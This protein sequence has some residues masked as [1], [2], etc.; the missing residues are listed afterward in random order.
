MVLT[1]HNE[2]RR[3]VARGDQKNK[4]GE[5]DLP[6]AKKMNELT[7]DCNMERVATDEAAKC[8]DYANNQLGVN[9]NTF[10]ASSTCNI[11]EKTQEVLNQWWDE[12]TTNGLGADQKYLDAS[13]L[14]N[15]ANMVY[16]ETN[17]FACSFAKCSSDIR[18]VCIYNKLGKENDKVLYEAAAGADTA[19]DDCA[20]GSECVARLCQPPFTLAA[21][22]PQVCAT[23][24]MTNDMSNMAVYMHNYYRALLGSGWAEDKISTYAPLA[25]AMPAL[26]YDCADLG[27][28][29]A[30]RAAACKETPD[31]PTATRSQNHLA[32]QNVNIDP[33]D[34]L[35]ELGFRFQEVGMSNLSN[36]FSAWEILPEDEAP[37]SIAVRRPE[38]PPRHYE[39]V[40]RCGGQLARGGSERGLRPALQRIPSRM[41][42]KPQTWIEFWKP[43]RN[44]REDFEDLVN[45]T[46]DILDDDGKKDERTK[47]QEKM[48][49]LARRYDT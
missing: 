26:S 4:A 29:A 10:A 14:D 40:N 11:T 30:A 28:E 48:L 38:L 20:A 3:T 5:A 27:T 17:A 15:F 43:P 42:L 31:A 44:C 25:K 21:E 2:K 41:C 23:D 32:I 18:L 34:A 36:S 45:V 49:E 12:L 13:K 39:A 8:V 46:E 22:D 35:K 16:E 6:A 1:F 7:W 9:Q 37:L 47:Q 33:E 24:S 19:C